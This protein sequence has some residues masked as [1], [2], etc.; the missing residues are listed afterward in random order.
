[1]I[2]KNPISLFRVALPWLFAASLFL[3][4]SPA[5][6]FAQNE[7]DELKIDSSLVVMN[8][9]VKDAT[10]RHVSGLRQPQFRIF[11]DGVEQ[12]VELFSSEE[13]P[14]A[15]VILL[16]TS[17]SMEERVSMARSAAIRFLD[18]LREDDNVAI[19]RFD[20]KI[21]LVQVFSNSRDIS[22]KAF[23]L[24]AY[25]MTKMNDAIYQAAVDLSNRPEKRRAI[26]VL[27]DGQDNM[28][29][30]SSDKVL[31]AALAADISIYTIDMSPLN[32]SKRTQNQGPL[33]NLAEKSG[34][35]FV[36]TPGGAAMRDAFAKIVEELG[37]QYTVGYSPANT[38]RDGKWRAI[39]LRIAKSDLTVRTKKGY[40]AEKEK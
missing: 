32:D 2:G 33:K 15:A 21:E 38:K 9:S 27:S 3:F 37:V 10:G 4:A 1:M 31:K 12:K 17:G 16:D 20:S 28:S 35:T 30:R 19:Y 40:N 18:G 7:D 39:E 13:T 11:E 23:D 14:F 6:L 29:G 34:G 22:E 8:V 25:G 24:K 36:A 26:I 5:L